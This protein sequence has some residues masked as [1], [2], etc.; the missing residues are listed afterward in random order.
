MMTATPLPNTSMNL[1]A[2]EVGGLGVGDRS[3]TQRGR[4]SVAGPQVIEMTFTRLDARKQDSRSA[5]CG[6]V[7]S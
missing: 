7:V 4:P 1:P 5:V 2:R 3:R 6:I